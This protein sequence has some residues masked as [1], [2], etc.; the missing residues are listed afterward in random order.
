MFPRLSLHIPRPSV[1]SVA[2]QEDNAWAHLYRRAGEAPLAQQVVEHF[3]LN[4]ELRRAHPAL[5][6]CCRES[7]RR[8]KARQARWTRLRKLARRL[9]AWLRV[10]PERSAPR[11]SPA[12]RFPVE[13]GARRPPGDGPLGDVLATAIVKRELSLPPHPRSAPVG[14]SVAAS[15]KTA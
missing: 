4:P 11:R 6:L 14:D 9:L 7:L 15:V 12:K 2:Q 10:K 3:D 1:A 5:Y 8:D 13:V